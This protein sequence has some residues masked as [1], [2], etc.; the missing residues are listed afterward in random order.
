M[1]LRTLAWVVVPAVV[2]VKE[3]LTD[4]QAAAGAVTSSA[5]QVVLTQ[6][7]LAP[8]YHLICSTVNQ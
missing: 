5:I 4:V 6:A 2:M 7:Q 3:V 1:A 8:G